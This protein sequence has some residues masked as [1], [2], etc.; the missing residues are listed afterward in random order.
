MEIKVNKA[1]LKSA[2]SAAK[3]AL[4]KTVIQEERAHLLFT[5]KDSSISVQA[6]NH[7][8][9]ALCV[10]PVDNVSGESFSFTADPKILEKLLTK[11]ELDTVRMSYNPEDFVLKVFT[12]D[13]NKSFSSLQS[14]PPDR[15]LTF[16]LSAETDKVV[17]P[18]KKDVLEFAL[19]YAGNYL[20]PIKDDQKQFDFVV[21]DKG[22]VYAANG[23]NKMGFIVFKA[24]EKMTNFKIRKA[25]LP[26]FRAFS[27]S[28]PGDT[29]NVIETSRNIGVESLDG[30]MHYSCLKS[31]TDPVNIPKEHI[32][33]EGPY[34]LVD[35]NKLL[36]VLDRLV[37]SNASLV[38]NGIELVINGQNEAALMD[39]TLMSALKT[40]ESFSCVRKDDDNPEPVT[41]VVDNKIFKS[42]LSSFSSDKEVRLHVCDS[43]RFYKIYNSGEISG[44]KYIL[45]GIGSYA[46]VIK[47]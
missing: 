4:S 46:K 35:K 15:M 9:K 29:V 40:T 31:N 2:V 8:L 43:N 1:G 17:Y 26:I 25:I 14:F 36:K 16:D 32:K 44:C 28:L 39:I 12:T 47:Q 21:I 10:L 42:I 7:D 45:A 33:S 6:T 41:H 30:S 18:V 24:F 3:K 27:D 34:I 38:G 22:I 37:V 5:V 20:S 23:S 11:I 19:S 13:S